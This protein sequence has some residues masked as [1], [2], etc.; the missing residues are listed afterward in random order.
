MMREID[1]C[2]QRIADAINNLK[3]K[4]L[5]LPRR[6]LAKTIAAQLLTLPPDFKAP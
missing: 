4:T 5:K 6:R 1:V 2:R 3:G